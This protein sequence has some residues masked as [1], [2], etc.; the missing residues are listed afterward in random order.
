MRQGTKTPRGEYTTKGYL[1]VQNILIGQRGEHLSVDDIYKL[2]D[3]KGEKIGRTTI[4][5]QLERLTAEGF[6][7][8]IT[9]EGAGACY[10]Y[11]DGE[12]RTHY[13]VICTSCG[14]LSHLSCE[15]VAALCS[16][17]QEEHGFVIDT[18]RTVFYGACANCLGKRKDVL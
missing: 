17:V 3:E 5:R 12:C 7:R 4:Y 1:L 16:H 14:A 15:H 8:K 2:L 11:L 13:H 6:A 9:C 18:A 10:S